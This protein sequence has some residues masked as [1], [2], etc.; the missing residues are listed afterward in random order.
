MENDKVTDYTH[1]DVLLPLAITVI[2]DKKVLQPEINSLAIQ[3]KHMKPNLKKSSKAR[4][5]IR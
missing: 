5:V 1:D 4:A 3:A 2:I